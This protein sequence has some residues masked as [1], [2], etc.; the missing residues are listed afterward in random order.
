MN[1]MFKINEVYTNVFHFKFKTQFDLCMSFLRIQEF[2]E[3]SYNQI[4]GKYF[5]LERYIEVSYNK[6]GKFSYPS[7]WKGFNIPNNVIRKFLDLF[8]NYSKKEVALFTEIIY[9]SNR[10]LG[11]PF[12]IIG[13]YENKDSTTLNHEIAHALFYLNKDYK[14]TMLGITKKYSKLYPV[15]FENFRKALLNDGYS[16]TVINDEIQAYLSEGNDDRYIFKNYKLKFP[17][18]VF[19]EYKKCFDLFFTKKK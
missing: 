4:R 13:T 7:D 1:K 10:L 12:Y 16:K 19:N 15:L 6:T 14:S 18:E 9:I 8:N 11:K 5:T 3:S 2:Y 17:K